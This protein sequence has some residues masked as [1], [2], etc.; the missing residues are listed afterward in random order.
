MTVSVKKVSIDLFYDILSPYSYIAFETLTRLN[1][2][3]DLVDLRLQPSLLGGILKSTGNQIPIT[4]PAKVKYMMLDLKKMCNY[5]SIPYNIPR[6]ALPIIHQK[7]SLAPQRLLVA[8]KEK[9]SNQLEP[10]TRELFCQLF[11]R[12]SDVSDTK[13]LIESCK[14]V[15]F[16]EIESKDLLSLS[17]HSEIKSMLKDQVEM[18]LQYG[19][20]GLPTYVAHFE[21]G[22]EMFFGCDRLSLLLHCL[23]ITNKDIIN[24][25]D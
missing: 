6:T 13:N 3:S 12:D 4:V 7:G 22:P 1:K 19:A 21:S 5:Y 18:A 2:K 16:S 8:V 10:L 15:G 25:I 17:N 23:K 20:F 14:N 11:Y 9:F 24:R